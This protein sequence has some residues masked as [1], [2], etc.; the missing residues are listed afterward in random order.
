ML[1]AMHPAETLDPV[2]E[3]DTAHNEAALWAAWNATKN[4]EDRHA[5]VEFYS[6][7]VHFMAKQVFVRVRIPGVEWHDFVH[8]GTIG[9]LEAIDR[10]EPERGFQFRTYARHRVR[11]AI[12]NGLRQCR[13]QEA[14]APAANPARHID[15]S[16][17]LSDEPG[18]DLLAEIV[19]V[20]VGL[21]IGHL[22]D[23][24]SLPESGD[25]YAKVE[26]DCL[27]ED[28]SALVEALPEKERI[29]VKYHYYQHLAFIEIAELL[30]V[31]KGRISQL[32]KQ[33]ILRMRRQLE[34][35]DTLN[36]V[37]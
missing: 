18:G 31:T 6:E 8:Y 35:A 1:S 28:L 11:G 4:P 20:S 32:H 16:E 3:A 29:V 17:S 37:A 10:F 22:L 21:A 12:L 33:G 14:H 34:A 15:R 30:G 36:I 13:D 26:H 7:W 27:M 23:A 9:L 19:T 25:T 5:I 2:P 24:D